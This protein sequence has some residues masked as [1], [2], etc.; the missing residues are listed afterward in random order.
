MKVFCVIKAWAK[1]HP[2]NFIRDEIFE[3][4]A[5]FSGPAIPSL[6]NKTPNG[7]RTLWETPIELE[8]QEASWIG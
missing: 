8:A 1:L 5:K 7:G 6:M 3:I 2:Q 4:F